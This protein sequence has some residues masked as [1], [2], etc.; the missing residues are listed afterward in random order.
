MIYD[1]AIE[2]VYFISLSFACLYFV[3]WLHIVH[4]I[5]CIIVAFYC[6]QMILLVGFGPTQFAAMLIGF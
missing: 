1:F 2:L 6:C 4:F 5:C 3:V